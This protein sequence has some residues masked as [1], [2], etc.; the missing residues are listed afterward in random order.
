MN[1]EHDLFNEEGGDIPF[2]PHYTEG[3]NHPIGNNRTVKDL[4]E[5]SYG[6]KGEGW[7]PRVSRVALGGAAIIAIV[8]TAEG[9]R[10][11]HRKHPDESID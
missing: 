11:F 6:A 9:I 5:D 7:F 1:N 2:P 10:H 4:Y 3:L 8:V